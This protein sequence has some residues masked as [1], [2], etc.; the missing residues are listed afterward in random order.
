MIISG[1][2]EPKGYYTAKRGSWRIMPSSHDGGHG[3]GLVAASTLLSDQH[4]DL[5]ADAK[6]EC[7]QENE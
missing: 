5:H 2:M 7:K 6:Q 4:V 3:I 1:R